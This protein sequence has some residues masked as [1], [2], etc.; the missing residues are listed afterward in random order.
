MPQADRD[1]EQLQLI[2]D[3]CCR[4]V[5]ALEFFGDDEGKFLNQTPFQD[6]C[7]LCLIQIGEAVNRISDSFKDAHPQISWHSIYG[8]RNHLMHAYGLFDTEIC[9]EAI[10]DD[11]P[12]LRHF[13]E[14]IISGEIA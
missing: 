1:I 5:Q 3:Y 10:H 7:A 9:W 12:V 2:V 6:C 14:G 13:C 4:L 11:V 8:M